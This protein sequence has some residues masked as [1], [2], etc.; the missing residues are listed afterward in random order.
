MKFTTLLL[1]L[2]A[3]L[4]CA[5]QAQSEANT[6]VTLQASSRLVV[7]DVVVTNRSGDPILDLTQNDFTVYEDTRPQQIRSFE[8]VQTHAMPSGSSGKLLVQSS[9]DLRKIGAAPVSVIVLDEINSKYEDMAYGRYSLQRYLL[10]QPKLL[11]QPTTLIAASSRQFRVLC[12]YT[13]DRDAL[14]D[15]LRKHSPAYPSQLMRT[16]LSGVGERIAATLSSVQEIAVAQAGTPG[17]KNLV[18]IGQGFPSIDGAL[19]D[20][21]QSERIDA[22]LRQITNVLLYGHVTLFVADPAGLQVSL[23]SGSSAGMIGLSPNQLQTWE[24]LDNSAIPFGGPLSF[25][26]L[27]PA[28][29]GRSFTNRND[30]DT[31]IATSIDDGASY[32][33]LSYIPE[34]SDSKSSKYRH[35]RVEIRHPDLL[36]MTRDGYFPSNNDPSASEKHN[37][38]AAA[39]KARSHD[40]QTELV[41]AALNPMNYNGISLHAARGKNGVYDID[42]RSADLSWIPLDNGLFHTSITLLAVSFTS[43]GRVCANTSHQTAGDIA[44]A[45]APGSSAR[46]LLKLPFDVP[47]T[48]THTRFVV[49]DSVTG[50]IGTADV[51]TA[52]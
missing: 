12:D 5:A 30:V 46:T 24:D 40:V 36:V 37:P 21:E 33:T 2:T 43:N 26:S 7:V 13:Q 42:V 25:A 4:H 39:A 48:A 8:S 47:Q 50:R 14:L 29:G 10:Q 20:R 45:P 28:T 44:R 51:N 22:A 16:S 52:P 3:H 17:R 9:A 19:L 15:A 6:P 32:Y 1:L 35:I 41:N 38:I 27:A 23:S 31:E 11:R 34:S 49:R 18:W